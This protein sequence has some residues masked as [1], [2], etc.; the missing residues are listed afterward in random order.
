MHSISVEQS[1]LV[2]VLRTAFEGESNVQAR[3]REFAEK[4]D[5][6]GWHGVAS[7]F[8]AA[9][10]AEEIHAANHGRIARQ[11]GGQV[12]YRPHSV[13]VKN[14]LTNLR[15]AVEGERFEVDTM[16]P[17]F[18]MQAQVHH[19]VAAIRTFTW[20]LEA[21]KTHVRLFNE[22]ET[23]VEIEEED[24]WVTMRRDFFVCPVCGYTSEEE[25]QADLC[26]VCNCAWK[27]FERLE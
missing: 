20:A 23:L 27:R 14:T 2:E 16:Y 11:L 10:R 13:E 19:D 26:P 6:E 18:V 5:G 15:T 22:A 1:T 12:E 21:E 3:Y 9:A 17:A 8:R 7:L 25:Y 24:S 4:A